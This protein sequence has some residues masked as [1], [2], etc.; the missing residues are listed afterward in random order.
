MS[1]FC[2]KPVF[3]PITTTIHSRL[4]HLLLNVMQNINP[5]F[6][7]TFHDLAHLILN[8]MKYSKTVFIATFHELAYLILNC[9]KHSKCI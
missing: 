9:K 4:E 2:F 7:G 5:V 1:C 8:F 3:I 6:I